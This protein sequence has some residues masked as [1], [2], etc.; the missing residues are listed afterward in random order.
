MYKFNDGWLLSFRAEWSRDFLSALKGD[1]SAYSTD[2]KLKRW[3]KETAK[4]K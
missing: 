4:V 3:D 2:L 1:F